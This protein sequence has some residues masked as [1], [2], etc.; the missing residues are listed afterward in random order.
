MR[1]L[2]TATKGAR[3]GAYVGLLFGVLYSFGGVVVDLL[4]IGLNLGT[5]M[6]F[7]ALVGMPVLFSAAGFFLGVLIAL[8]SQAVGAILDRLQR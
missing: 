8:V 3:W 4:T 1:I 2:P 6:A 7:G 5:L